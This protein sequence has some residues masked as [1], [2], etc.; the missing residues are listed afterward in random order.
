MIVQYYDY[1]LT[2]RNTFGMKVKCDRWI[3]YDS[4]RDLPVIFRELA[5]RWMH[6]GAGSNLLFTGDYHGAVLHSSIRGLEADGTVIT[7]G[8]AEKLDDVVSW[9]CYHG[10]WGLENLSAIPGEMGAAAVQ[11]VG[12]YGV[13]ISDLI[14]DVMVFDTLTGQFQ[15][16]PVEGVGYGYRHS[17]F[18]DAANKGRFIVVSIRLKLSDIPSPVLTHSG[19]SQF[20][21]VENLTPEV[22]RRGV[23]AV[24]DSK[25]PDPRLTG[26]AGSFFKNPVVSAAKG[27]ELLGLY[28]DMPHYQADGGIKIP[29]AWLIERAGMKGRSVGGA[30]VWNR[31]PLV[32]VNSNGF[33]LPDDVLSLENEI[34]DAVL[35]LFGV[36]LFPEVEHI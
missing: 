21:D 2:G 19:L 31:Q 30:S 17:M 9:A 32:I 15:T 4:P 20:I 1:D 29:A 28:P 11:N 12:A 22:V 14:V 25:L 16:I 27:A 5:G 13:E 33:A 35:S 6:I 10:L 8:A 24:R 34:I 18:K 36:K 3:D 23:I 7:V 26:S